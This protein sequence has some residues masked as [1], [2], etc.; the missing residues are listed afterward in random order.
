MKNN[1]SYKLKF[2]TEEAEKIS[3]LRG[4]AQFYRIGP[5]TI[6]KIESDDTIS[7]GLS[8]CGDDDVFAK[9]VGRFWAS[10]RALKA[11]KGHSLAKSTV[12]QKG[13]DILKDHGIKL[14]ILVNAWVF[15]GLGKEEYYKFVGSI[16]EMYKVNSEAI[17]A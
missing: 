1:Y 17:V 11:H 10:S 13:L 6:C 2:I 14:K 5:I 7:L 4:V 15:R 9:S 12:S 16:T 8:I 3:Q